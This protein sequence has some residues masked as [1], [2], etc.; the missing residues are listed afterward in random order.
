MQDEQAESITVMVRVRPLNEMENANSKCITIE[1]DTLTVDAEFDAKSY[2]FDYIASEDSKQE[3]I[4]EVIGKPLTSSFIKGYNA[5]VVAYGQTGSGKTY[6]IEGPTEEQ[7]MNSIRQYE[8]RGLMPRIFEHLFNNIKQEIRC[9]YL[10]IYKEM[11]IDLLNPQTENLHIRENSNGVYVEN[12]TEEVVESFT[13]LMELLKKGKFNRHMKSTAMNRE[14]SRSHSIFTLSLSSKALCPKFTIVDLAG[15]ERQKFSDA[16]GERLKEAGK[17]NKSL[18]ALNNVINSLVDASQ[19]KARHIHYRDSK[20]T[21]L[22]KN[23]LDG[24]SKTVIIVN[25][26]QSSLSL[27]ETI[28]TLNFAKRAKM[29]RNKISLN[30]DSM[31]TIA[32]LQRE[33]NR[34]RAQI[35]VLKNRRLKKSHST[36]FTSDSKFNLDFRKRGSEKIFEGTMELKENKKILEE[37]SV[38]VLKEQLTNYQ[39]DRSRKLNNEPLGSSSRGKSLMI[40]RASKKFITF[41]N[42]SEY[43]DKKAF[44][45][46]EYIK[47][48]VKENNSLK[49]ALDS[50]STKYSNNIRRLK[51]EYERTIDNLNAKYNQ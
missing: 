26:S 6:T 48:L 47:R 43:K 17:I 16:A 37:G 27:G 5:T 9:T 24:N 13:Q 46:T 15:S 33:V 12:I 23:S 29:I 36:V 1:D 25:V 21:F 41:S 20:L 42:Q 7:M 22:L 18:L 11:I 28:S 14:S 32:L 44:K 4:F 19:G 38:E 39:S 35:S 40:N 51:Q 10:E 3:D 49:R 50:E 45:H 30:Y 31:E 2:S 34:L 8:L